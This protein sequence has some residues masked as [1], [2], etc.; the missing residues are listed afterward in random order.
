M[1]SDDKWMRRAIR[2]AARGRGRVHPNPMVGAVLV[3]GGRVVGEG[4]HTRFGR[5][6]AEAE[7][8]RRA[9]QR[10][11][12]ST[13]YVNL[14][15][16]AH[17]GKTPP[18]VDAIVQA[19][20][21]RVVAAM[22]DPNPL[23]AG[24]GFSALRRKG[25]RISSGFLAREA[26]QLNRAFLTWMRKG[27][28]YVTLKAAASLDGLAATR[29]G[30]SK[31][32]TGASAR[33][34]GHRLRGSADAVAVGVN[35]VLKDNPS[36]RAHGK[37]NEPVRVIFDSRLQTPIGSQ[38][39]KGTPVTWLMATRGA[40]IR[41]V[42]RFEKKGATVWRLPGNAAGEVDIMAALTLLA[43]EGIAHLLVEGGPTL[44]R[45][46]LEAGVVDEVAWF[47]APVILGQARHLK[48]ALRLK[49]VRVKR[50]GLDVGIRG[51][52]YRNH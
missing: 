14:E 1:N 23:V 34:E 20:V 32:I 6:H 44:Q 50:L 19:G 48:E 37:G 47:V 3:R 45:S 39:L 35:T 51:Y 43:R 4:F 27:R 46:F 42:R 28:P 17:W 9:G 10:A 30:E 52:V 13:L 38:V 26:R 22:R 33:A 49:D 8:I 25:V 11:R 36:L 7:A 15:P 40:P 24:K 31:W 5:A 18:C 2:L 21:R 16:C 12:G 41:R 29:T